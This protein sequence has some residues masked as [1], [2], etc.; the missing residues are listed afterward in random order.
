MILAKLNLN[1]LFA[2][3]YSEL[4]SNPFPSQNSQISPLKLQDFL[5]NNFQQFLSRFFWCSQSFPT[6]FNLESKFLFEIH[7]LV[8]FLRDFPIDSQSHIFV[9][10]S[11]LVSRDR[12]IG[13]S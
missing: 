3:L 8:D 9:V 10:P 4:S 12:V 7:H 11:G 6:S 5:P 1:H 2:E 13:Q